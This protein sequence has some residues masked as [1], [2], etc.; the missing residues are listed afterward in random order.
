MFFYYPCLK[1][2]KQVAY[3]YKNHLE[4]Y[5]MK[6]RK[7]SW[8][9]MLGLVLITLSALLYFVHYEFFHDAHHI[10]IYLLGDIAFVPIEVLLVT[11]VL[12]KLLTQR[13]KRILLKKMNMV[14]GV[15]FSEAGTGLLEMLKNFD[16]SSSELSKT[17]LVNTSWSKKNFSQLI[18]KLKSRPYSV[19][20]RNS[21]LEILKSELCSKRMFLLGLL[22]NPNLLEHDSFTE[23]L[24]AVFHLA[25]ELEAR[26][27]FAGLPDT[28]LNHLSGDILRVYKALLRE[29]ILYMQHLKN[30]YPYLFSLAVRTNP[31]DLNAEVK[32][33]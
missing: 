14:I 18:K 3:I 9:L 29:W 27:D 32:V 16:K 7:I 19:D 30:D 33:S 1:D 22:E 25:E 21:S 5:R 8:Q 17:L 31:F 2:K 13:E 6:N 4:S 20:S 12:H 26:K 11:L 23:L 28:D 15:F 10:F 24:W